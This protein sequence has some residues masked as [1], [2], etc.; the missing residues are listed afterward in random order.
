[1]LAI[2]KFLVVFPGLAWWREIYDLPFDLFEQ[3]NDYADQRL[4]G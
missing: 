4:G 1:M 2:P 3:M